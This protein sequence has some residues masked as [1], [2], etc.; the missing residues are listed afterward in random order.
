MVLLCFIDFNRL[1]SPDL[2]V[3]LCFRLNFIVGPRPIFG[4]FMISYGLV[5]FSYGFAMFPV[6]V[7]RR[8]SPELRL[9]YDFFW[10]SMVFLWFFYVSG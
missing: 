10:F 7:N 3:L 8:P 2:M 5:L 9:S 6:D 4:Y 1:H